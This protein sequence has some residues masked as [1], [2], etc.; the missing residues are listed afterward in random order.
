MF[1]YAC[2]GAIV[3]GHWPYYAN[4]DPKVLPGRLLLNFIGIVMLIGVLSALLL[5]F[6]YATW[7]I[8]MHLRHRPLPKHGTWVWVYAAG[9][10]IWILDLTALYEWMSWHSLI[11]WIID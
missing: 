5:P 10:V 6:G 11:S 7:R 8:V 1:A 4:P 2:Y 9:L 3:V